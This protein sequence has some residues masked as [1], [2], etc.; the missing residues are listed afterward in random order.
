M[1]RSTNHPASFL[2]R[3]LVGIA[4]GAA[5]SLAVAQ[6][7]PDPKPAQPTA[8]APAEKLPSADEVV[9]KFIKASGGAEAWDKV[10]TMTINGAFELAGMNLKGKTSIWIGEKGKLLN[11]TELPG[12]GEIKQGSDG[13]T[14]WSS[15]AAM[16]PRIV[17]GEERETLA[18]MEKLRDPQA[19][20]TEFKT[21]E[22]A[23]VTDIDSKPAY[24]LVAT[25]KGKDAQ[26]I[27]SYFDK[28]SGLLVKMSMTMSS[29]QGEVR[30]EVFSSDYKEKDGVV[31]SMK[32]R[33]VIGGIQE[34][35]TT[36]EKVEINPDIPAEKFE[37]PADIKALKDA[38]KPATD[39][40]ATD[41]PAKDKPAEPAPD[42]K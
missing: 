35:I 23:G 21:L 22:V 39:K 15:D 13:E 28:E 38:A 34:I 37:L 27:T 10:K 16:G 33:M 32:S 7:A 40:P 9:D 30:I 29:P 17:E 24:K 5:G 12:F 31:M 3:V 14:M 8:P 18:L 2:F 1:S 20:K 11:V 19:M 41:K 26:P 42:K 4:S 25:P 6:P 36:I